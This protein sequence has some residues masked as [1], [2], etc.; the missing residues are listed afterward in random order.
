MVMYIKLPYIY[1]TYLDV[2]FQLAVILLVGIISI[3]IARLRNYFRRARYAV[4]YWTILLPP[5]AV[6]ATWANFNRL[7]YYVRY[8]ILCTLKRLYL[9]CLW[10]QWYLFKTDA[11]RVWRHDCIGCVLYCRAL[12]HVFIAFWRRYWIGR[13]FIFVL[14][15][16]ICRMRRISYRRHLPKRLIAN[17]YK[18]TVGSIIPWVWRYYTWA[19]AWFLSG[20][21]FHWAIYFNFLTCFYHHPIW[22]L[23]MTN[24]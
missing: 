9:R 22:F 14:F 11:R 19:G 6:Q 8:I 16:Y 20:Y 24:L 17:V 4:K 18:T 13:T 7:N 5:K 2:K 12:F 23:L 1:Y 3:A 10:Y 15:L 21:I